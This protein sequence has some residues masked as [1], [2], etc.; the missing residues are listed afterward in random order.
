MSYDKLPTPERLNEA[1]QAVQARGINVVLVNTREEALEKLKEL[2]PAGASLMTGSSTTLQQIGFEDLLISKQHPWNN[3]KDAILAEKDPQKQSELR[4]QSVLADYFLGS[5][6]A[7]AASGELLIAS[8]TGSQLPAYAYSSRNVVWVAGAQKIVADLDEAFRRV[9]EH[10]FP[11]ED[12]RMK[13]AGFRGATL[14]KWLIFERESAFLGRGVTLVLVNERLGFCH[15]VCSQRPP[16]GGR[17]L[18]CISGEF[19]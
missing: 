7:V 8:S 12:Q 11:L 9:R 6:H 1:I 17:C 4:R 5:V 18:I 14:G 15:W 2:I 3:L 16:N 10:V 19:G 13:N